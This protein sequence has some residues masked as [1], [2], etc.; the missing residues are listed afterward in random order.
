M[1]NIKRQDAFKRR[2]L[3]L[4]LSSP[5]GAGKTTIA[6]EILNRDPNLVMSISATTRSIRPGEIEGK[7]YYFIDKKDFEARINSDNFIEYARV[8]DNYY[9][10]PK[11]P[12]EKEMS[13]GHD[14]HFD[15]DW[16][17]TQQLVSKQNIMQDVVTI[18]ILPPN[19][20]ELGRRL[21]NRAQDSL[22]VVKHRMSKVSD[23]LSHYP[24]YQY[25]IVN[26][27]IRDSVDQVEQIL[28]AERCKIER[29][30]GLH[31]FVQNL[32]NLS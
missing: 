21:E 19:V 14:I 10:T 32:R 5:S 8:F 6:R 31:D 9:G 26:S 3:M 22:A 28:S 7:D 27:E 20:S 2:G 1:R 11:D 30:I 17:G 24:E 15:I 29:Q 25:V 18:F 13:A 12:V 16:Q 23:E 4:V